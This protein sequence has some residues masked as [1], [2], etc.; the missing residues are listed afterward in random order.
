MVTKKQKLSLKNGKAP[1]LLAKT[2]MYATCI[3]SCIL[4]VIDHCIIIRLFSVG[5][6]L[7]DPI[8]MIH[9]DCM[10]LE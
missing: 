10:N 3:T 6:V 4:V 9:Q 5:C 2:E 8:F 1:F 7:I